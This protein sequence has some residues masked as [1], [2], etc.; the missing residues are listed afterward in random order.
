[1]S[2][3]PRRAWFEWTLLAL[4]SF[5][6]LTFV[7]SRVDLSAVVSLSPNTFFN[8]VSFGCMTRVQYA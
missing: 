4:I 7:L 5:A 8:F 3:E 2:G 1:M 6:L